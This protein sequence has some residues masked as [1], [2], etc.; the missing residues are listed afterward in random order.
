LT[1]V[2]AIVAAIRV[3]LSPASFSAF[4]TGRSFGSDAGYE[5]SGDTFSPVFPKDAA[6]SFHQEKRKDNTLG[7]LAILRSW[8]QL[9]AGCDNAPRASR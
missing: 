3:R 2:L 7:I 9:T 8:T 1:V 5:A 4:G 6:E